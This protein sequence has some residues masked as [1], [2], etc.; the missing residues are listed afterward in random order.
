MFVIVRI[1]ELADGTPFELFYGGKQ[2]INNPGVIWTLNRKKATTFDDKKEAEL[3]FNNGGDDFKGAT[4]RN[5]KDTVVKQNLMEVDAFSA[6]LKLPAEDLFNILVNSGYGKEASMSK[7]SSKDL[8]SLIIS[9]LNRLHKFEKKQ[10]RLMALDLIEASRLSYSFVKEDGFLTS[11][12]DE[13]GLF[14]LET[15]ARI[16]V[17]TSK[18]RAILPD[19]SNKWLVVQ[20]VNKLP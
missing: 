4:I 2:Y 6:L 15:A 3:I 20:F 7:E 16:C 13:A 10:N 18:D 8:A 1:K 17:A 5:I 19:A 14:D 11:N 12:Y 9:K